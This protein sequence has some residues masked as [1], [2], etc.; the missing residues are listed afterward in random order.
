MS[1][2]KKC[3]CSAL[4]FMNEQKRKKNIKKEKIIKIVWHFQCEREIFSAFLWLHD[5]F[6]FLSTSVLLRFMRCSFSNGF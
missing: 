5:D 3:S 2:A 6:S 1:K 4:R